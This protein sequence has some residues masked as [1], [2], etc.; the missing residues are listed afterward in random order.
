MAWVGYATMAP[1]D[2]LAILKYL[3]PAIPFIFSATDT[4]SGTADLSAAGVAF[5][6]AL[7]GAMVIINAIG[8]RFLTA[9]NTSLT[10]FKIAAPVAIAGAIIVTHFDPSNFSSHGFAP[11][12]FDGVMAAV[13]GGGVVFAFIGFRHVIDL[14]GEARNPQWTIPIAL[15]GSVVVGT[16]IY[17][18]MQIAFVGGIP[19]TELSKGWAGLSINHLYGPFAA[20]AMAI[21][22][23]WLMAVIYG[24]AVISPFSSALVAVG[25]NARLAMALARS[26]FF[27]GFVARLSDRGVPFYGLLVNFAAGAML[28]FMLDLPAL[29]ALN[30]AA[31]VV[32]FLVGPVALYALRLQI[33]ERPR[34]M[35][36]PVVRIF[37]G[38]CFVLSTY[39]VYWSGWQTISVL[40]LTL[41]AGVVLF[42]VLRL[43]GGAEARPALDLSQSYWVAVFLAAMGVISYLGDFGGGTGTIPPGWDLALIAALSC[44]IFVWA[45]RSRLSDDRARAKIE[46]VENAP[47][48]AKD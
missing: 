28:V 23:P 35:R 47:D 48:A 40:G 8:V 1:I 5:A 29:V 45:I 11:Q 10:W 13:S 25:S 20:I 32:S 30:G 24:S 37:S 17:G 39:V 42:L 19:A 26:G 22:L 7:L 2:V 3:G 36:V 38:V 21:G 44:S 43:F 9:I 33:P 15:T 41:A 14:A 46:E 4:A 18:A 34:K 6:V 12:G 31:V 27:P 16:V